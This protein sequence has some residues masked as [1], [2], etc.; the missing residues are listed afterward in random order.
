MFDADSINEIS[1]FI[2]KGNTYQADEGY[3]DDLVMCLVL[4]GWVT[5]QTFFSDLTDINVRAGI[6]NQQINVIE[7]SLTPFVITQYEEQETFV[8]GGDLWVIDDDYAQ[9]AKNLF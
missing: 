7:N 4:F 9:K 5:S 8:D 6:Y 3:H 1:T 2:E